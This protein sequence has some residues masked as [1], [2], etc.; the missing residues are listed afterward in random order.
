MRDLLTDVAATHSEATLHAQAPERHRAVVEI[1]Q[2]ILT[3][4]DGVP[5]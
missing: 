1:V 2:R 4:K 5:L 3:G